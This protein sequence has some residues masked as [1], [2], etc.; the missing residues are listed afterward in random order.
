MYT[1]II[2]LLLVSAG[3]LAGVGIARRKKPWAFAGILVGM[4]TLVFFWFL[5]FWSEVLWFEALG[6]ARR[7][8]T[9]VIAQ[10]A[11][12]AA[13]AVIAGAAVF[14]AARSLKR[15]WNALR[16][17]AAAVAGLIGLG[18]GFRHWETVLL[19]VHG[20]TTA[21]VDPILGMDTGFYFFTLPFMKAVYD[22]LFAPV[23]L[24][25]LLCAGTLFL[26]YDDNSLRVAVPAKGDRAH[27]AISP[28]AAAGALLL[29]LAF[30]TWLDCFDLLYS[31]WGT[32]AGA[33]W[34]DVHVRLPAYRIVA[35]V[36]A[37]FGIVLLAGP[38]RRRL[39]SGPLEGLLGR[40]SV[41]RRYGVPAVLAATGAAVLGLWIVLLGLAPALVQ[42]LK[43]EPNEITL[44]KP[45]IEHNI[46]F[47]RKGFRLDRV[48]ERQYPAAD[49][50]TTT[51]LEENKKLFENIRLWDYRAL[52]QVYEQFQEIRL[53]YRFADVDIDRYTIGDNYR[54]VMVSAR[55]MD[56]GNLPAGSKTFVNRHF[57]YTHGNGITL[58]TVSDFTPEGLPKLLVKDIPPV[59][60]HSD[61]AIDQPRIYYG[62][63]TDTFCIA[64]S[65]EGEF[66]Y[67]RGDTNVYN[68]YD[69][70]GG[71]SIGSLWRRFLFGWRYGGTRL[72]LSGY[73]R[74]GSRIMFHRTIRD[75]VKRIAPFLRLDRDPY[76]VL[77]GGRLYWIIDAYTTS[78]NYPYSEPFRSGRG[79]RAGDGQTGRLAAGDLPPEMGGVNYMRNAVKVVVDAY[80]G[81]VDL[82]VIDADD[83]LIRAWRNIF[84]GVFKDIDRMG[85]DLFAHVRYPADLLLVQGAI[86]S[87]Y[88]MTDPEVFYNQEDLWVRATEKYY[89]GVQPIQPY[90]MMWKPPAT[91]AQE[92]IQML[93][94]NPKNKQVLIGW[95][96]GM[97][98]GDNYGRFL[99]YKFPKEKRLIGPQQ[100]ETKIDQDRY[101][102]ERLTLWD[103]RGSTVIRGNVLAIP[104]AET[105][106][107][108][109]PIYIQADAA[110]YPELRLVV[111]MEGDN[112]S[113]AESFSKAMKG[114]IE[115]ATQRPAAAPAA[116]PPLAGEQ[117][118][119]L[120]EADEAFAGYLRLNGEK[121]F[122]E[123]AAKLERLGEILDRLTREAPGDAPKGKTPPAPGQK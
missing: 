93:P 59:A 110:A 111:L 23:L 42:W 78:E 53:Y 112:M 90:Y 91:A 74:A 116:G 76:I 54:Q 28:F 72:L 115:G 16:W 66:D 69:G 29:V 58:T 47:T 46:H 12:A 24:A 30:G 100:V 41:S 51:A 118:R 8:W 21:T 103:Q 55:E 9:V 70:T 15:D 33:G 43:V 45:Y 123:A 44:E 5:G 35:A 75:R 119:L 98:D 11:L 31:R 52:G 22:L 77:A 50:I 37:V 17:G 20:G 63:L 3:L 99:A 13:G 120:R 113:Y 32:V 25:F 65:A 97:C 121:R 57:K 92:Y 105:I 88:H 48:E 1:A 18:W 62:E 108:V 117:L 19:F 85:P 109:E 6:Y 26:R 67:P 82:Y 61:L 56:I 68:H 4:F 34:T 106:L 104:V 10:V 107:Y 27:A 14:L 84:P 60:S 36:T 79:P 95:I 81:A 73:P 114:L 122:A 86:F 83:P 71:V 2:L 38:V 89:Q 64:N 49:G 80:N 94:F 7:L 101:L 39:L 96:A 102:S 40:W 87:K